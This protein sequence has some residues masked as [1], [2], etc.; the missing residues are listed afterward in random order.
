MPALTESRHAASFILTE[1]NGHRSRDNGVLDTG[2]LAAGT[3]VMFSGTK[4][5]AFA[6]DE[7]TDGSLV[8]EA[9][10]ILIYAA[11]ASSADQ[12]VAYIARDAEVNLKLLTYPAETTDGG[13]EAHTI[14]SLKKLGIVAR[15]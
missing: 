4:L 11:D 12:D 15:D 9:A 7:A 1:A 10:G 13:E 6:V 8:T 3:V 2:D 5:V 14:A